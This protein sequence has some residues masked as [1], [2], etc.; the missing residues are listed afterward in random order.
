VNDLAREF[1]EM[2]SAAYAQEATRRRED[3]DRQRKLVGDQY[4]RREELLTQ[5]RPLRLGE[6]NAWL[7]GFMLAGGRPTHFYNYPTPLS[8]WFTA[9]SDVAL[10]PLYG[11]FALEIVV[12]AGVRDLGGDTG[13][14]SLFITTSDGEFLGRRF[15]DTGPQTQLSFVPVYTDTEVLA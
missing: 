4:E 15:R 13:H 7:T 5:L 10:A 2:R 1:E 8:E 9:V 3:E 12:P 14:T 6:Y 11:S